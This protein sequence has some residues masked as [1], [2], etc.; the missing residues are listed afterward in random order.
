MASKLTFV[1]Q[2]C[3]SQ[4]LGPQYPLWGPHRGALRSHLCPASHLWL[5][6]LLGWLLCS[7]SHHTLVAIAQDCTPHQCCHLSNKELLMLVQ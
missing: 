6:A 5:L 3:R 4:A 1:G 2:H 7:S